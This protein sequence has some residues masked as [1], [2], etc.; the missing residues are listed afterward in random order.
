MK[1]PIN[2]LPY[3]EVSIMTTQIVAKPITIYSH[4]TRTEDAGDIKPRANQS[5]CK[6]QTATIN[7]P[8]INNLRDQRPKSLQ[9]YP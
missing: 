8:L 4:K 1:I 5:R 2:K 6:K 7:R 3:R 9:Q